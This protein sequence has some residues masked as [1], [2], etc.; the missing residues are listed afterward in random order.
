MISLSILSII[1]P[2]I[3][4]IAYVNLFFATLAPITLIASAVVLTV[5]IYFLVATIN[6]IGSGLTISATGGSKLKVFSWI[7][8]AC[9]AVSGIYWFLIWFVHV[10]RTMIIRRQR[11]KEDIGKWSGII[12]RTRRNLSKDSEKGIATE[13]PPIALKTMNL[14]MIPRMNSNL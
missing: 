7:A 1:F 10:R 11:N 4:F 5:L 6:G 13:E 14:P 2:R 12:G 8:W 9:S 3:R